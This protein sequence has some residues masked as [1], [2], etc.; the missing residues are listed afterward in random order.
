MA[1]IANT[2][3]NPFP[4]PANSYVERG[5]DGRIYCLIQSSTANTWDLWRSINSGTSWAICATFVRA[6]IIEVGSIQVLQKP[7]NQI[8][9][10]YRVYESGTDKVYIRTI[11]DLGGTGTY[12][13]NAE[14]LAAAVTAASAGAVLTGMDICNFTRPGVAHYVVVA[15]GIN[16]GGKHGAHINIMS[17]STLAG[18]VQ[19]NNLISGSRLWTPDSG[20][21][22]VTPSIDIEHNGDGHSSN[23][24]NILLAWGRTNAWF[25]RLTWNGNGWTGPSNAQQLNPVTLT[26]AQN[27]MSARWDGKRHLTCFPDPVSTSTVTVCERNQSNTAMV[28]RSSPTHPQGVVRHCTLNYNS[29]TGDFRIFAVGTANSAAYYVDYVRATGLWSAWAAVLLI[30]ISGSSGQNFTVRRSTDGAARHDFVASYAV[31]PPNTVNAQ[32]QVL[33]YTPN[34][35][36]WDNA[37]M[38]VQ[39][40]QAVDVLNYFTLDWT[41]SDPDPADTQGSYAVS[42]QIGAGA[43]AYYRASDGTWQPAEVQNASASTFLSLP[44][45]WQP[46]TDA[47]TT[48]RVKVWDAA[49]SPASGYGASLVVVPSTVVS[50]APAIA[51]PTVNQVVTADNISVTWTATEQSAW[52]GRLLQMLASDTWTRTV[53]AGSLGNAEFPATSNTWQLSTTA[54]DY[55][56]TGSAATMTHPTANLLH[57]AWV[58]ANST[59]QT[60]VVDISVPLTNPTGGAV[61]KWALARVQDASNYYAV[62]L[63]ITTGG[64]VIMSIAKRVAGALSTNLNG[65]PN[66]ALA[67]SHVSGE[68]WRIVLDVRGTTLRCKA[69]RRASNAEPDWQIV[70]TDTSLTSGTKAGWGSRL[71]AGNS[72]TGTAF[73]SDNF[74]VYGALTED[75]GWRSTVVTSWAPSTRLPDLSAWFATVNTRN[76]EGLQSF[77]QIQPFTVDYIEPATPTLAVAP[78]PGLG[79]IRVSITNPA[80]GGGQPDVTTQTLYRRVLG[81]GTSGVPVTTGI[82]SGAVYDDFRAVAGVVYEYRALATGTNGT[83]TYSAWTQ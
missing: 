12:V 77:E 38:G 83:S 42:R 64:S 8:V 74:H 4:Y 28:I 30:G 5:I 40:G 41:F 6:N 53:G 22:Q 14:Q 24:P 7:Y 73:S 13:W 48:F 82:A 21:G 61:S 36:A 58:E 52:R 37:A 45:S 31:G 18:A 57:V 3:A 66:Y 20:S 75:T 25:A 23:N 51:T 78:I 81:D 68:V 56:V 16:Q 49:G 69:F 1:D 55:A 67:A 29:V 35:A 65:T 34:T 60:V 47:A 76:L 50:L 63:Q 33:T 46:A 15:I 27:Y 44:P 19:N 62:F 9:A 39:N 11:S 72:N 59:D 26:P 43:L 80:P 2:T 79:I 71:E 32:H 70:T 17:G 10:C 54:A